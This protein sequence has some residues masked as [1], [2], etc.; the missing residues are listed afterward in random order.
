VYIQP[1]AQLRIGNLMKRM[2]LRIVGCLQV[3]DHIHIGDAAI[4]K[5][6]AVHRDEAFPDAMTPQKPILAEELPQDTPRDVGGGD[7]CLQ[8]LY[9]LVLRIVRQ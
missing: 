2:V 9:P 6:A 5:G 1:P 8:K 4:E 7:V 3:M